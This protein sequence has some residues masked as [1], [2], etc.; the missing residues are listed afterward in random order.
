LQDYLSILALLALSAPF[1]FCKLQIPLTE[2]ETDPVSGHHFQ[3]N[4]LA[5]SAAM[6]LRGYSYSSLGSSW[7]YRIDN[8]PVLFRVSIKPVS[9]E[10]LSTVFLFAL[11]KSRSRSRLGA[12]W[13]SKVKFDAAI[14][15]S[16]VKT[17]VGSQ[18]SEHGCRRNGQT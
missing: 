9:D 6:I 16:V 13:G 7:N 14:S 12:G 8:V 17:K 5:E 11:L 2:G 18:S 15:Q 4:N 1:R 10:L 3:I